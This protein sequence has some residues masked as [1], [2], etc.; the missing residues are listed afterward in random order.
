MGNFSL[1]DTLS[2][3]L[4]KRATIYYYY[5]YILLSASHSATTTLTSQGQRMR[6]LGQKY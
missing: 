4:E 1:L 5:Y 6:A 3:S 2:K